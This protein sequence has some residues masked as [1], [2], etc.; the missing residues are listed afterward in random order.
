MTTVP[1]DPRNGQQTVPR[2]RIFVSYRR[3]DT[4]GWAGRLYDDLSNRFGSANVFRDLDTLKP[5]RRFDDA[6]KVALESCDVVLC[7]VGPRWLDLKTD[8][9]QRRLD[10]PDDWIKIEIGEALKHPHV[11]VIPVRLGGAARSD[12]RIS[13]RRSSRWR[14]S[15]TTRSQ[16]SAGRTTPVSSSR[17]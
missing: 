10:D 11:M 13:L 15:E 12:G 6:I 3:E 8:D 7:L 17:T 1:S 9:G 2:M 16:T 5:G 4:A 14:E